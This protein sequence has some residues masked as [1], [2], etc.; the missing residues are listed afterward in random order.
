MAPHGAPPKVTLGP[1]ACVRHT[2]YSASWP[3]R[4]LH[5]WDRP[6]SSST[7]S[8]A[9]RCPIGSFTE[10]SSG[11]ARVRPP[12]ALRVPPEAAPAT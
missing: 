7:P 1:L 2:Q 9:N 10:G 5:R 8:T 6:R 4:E 11:T 12:H 3:H